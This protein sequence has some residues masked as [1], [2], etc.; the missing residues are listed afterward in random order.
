MN[1]FFT[2][3]FSN[4]ET[5]EMASPG[6]TQL[7]SCSQSRWWKPRKLVLAAHS[8]RSLLTVLS[9]Q[10]AASL[11]PAARGRAG[12]VCPAPLP[13]GGQALRVRS[14]PRA[15]GTDAFPRGSKGPG[16]DPAR[17]LRARSGLQRFLINTTYL[18][19]LCCCKSAFLWFYS[20]ST[21]FCKCS[22]FVTLWKQV[23]SRSE[24]LNPWIKIKIPLCHTAAV[25]YQ[26]FCL[27][28]VFNNCT[29][30]HKFSFQEGQRWDE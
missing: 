8:S 17:T 24:T 2:Y 25:C 26:G 12:R 27:F 15:M 7:S 9:P 20:I 14:P 3:E 6:D 22:E 16:T 30:M 28:V 23:S 19:H 18:G 5:S 29:S 11:G 10:G 13:G 4:D 1:Y 21:L